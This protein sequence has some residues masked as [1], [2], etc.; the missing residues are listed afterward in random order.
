MRITFFFARKGVL[1]FGVKNSFR[2]AEQAKTVR[3]NI[4]VLPN[5][6]EK[7]V[8]IAEQ[9]KTARTNI[10]VLAEKYSKKSRNF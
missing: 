3:T 4:A 8:F 2:I 7:L 10:A 1:F 5:K 9:A 6:N